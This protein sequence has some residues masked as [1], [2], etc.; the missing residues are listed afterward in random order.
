MIAS[1]VPKHMG[2]NPIFKY[3]NT[4]I[5]LGFVQDIEN[6]CPSKNSVYIRAVGT[7]LHVAVDIMSSL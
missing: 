7:L 5:V 4:T 6:H 2:R 3:C 1:Q